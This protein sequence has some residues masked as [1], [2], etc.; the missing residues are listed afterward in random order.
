MYDYVIGCTTSI[1]NDLGDE[2]TV[3]DPSNE[4]VSEKLIQTIK[5]LPDGRALIELLE[6]TH[7]SLY[8]GDLI[9]L[10]EVQGMKY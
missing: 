1:F 5:P 3:L 8:E 7:S 2:F 9:M 10:K 6:G 4:E